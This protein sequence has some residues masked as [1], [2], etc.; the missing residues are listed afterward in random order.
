[1][2]T[3]SKKFIDFCMNAISCRDCFMHKLRSCAEFSNVEIDFPNKKQH[4]VLILSQEEFQNIME[5]TDQS[6]F[7]K[8]CLGRTCSDC[9][10]Y[11][12]DFCP[13]YSSGFMD[14]K[15]GFPTRRGKVLILLEETL[16]TKG[17]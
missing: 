13:C 17:S 15:G 11:Y 7:R 5:K 12:P 4:K 6:Q 16:L 1:M 14:T 2:I 8:F 10:L 9:S 3:Y